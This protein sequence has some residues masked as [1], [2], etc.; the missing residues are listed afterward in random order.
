MMIKEIDKTEAKTLVQS[1]HYLGKKGFRFGKAY[2]LVNEQGETVGAAVFHSPSAPET[3][4][5]AF[6]LKREEQAGIWELGRFVLHPDYNGNNNGSFLLGRAI[7]ALRRSGECKALITYADSTFHYGALYQATNFVY[8][9]LTTQKKD[10]WTE[11]E[12]G[13]WKIKERGKTKGVSG[14]WRDR[15]RKHRYVMVFEKKMQLK[16]E[17]CPYIKPHGVKPNE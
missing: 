16:W 2:G 5:G 9:G 12:S 3:V 14:E 6:G 7:K 8:C 17:P 10:F 11:N 13:E 1:F 15:P 4:V